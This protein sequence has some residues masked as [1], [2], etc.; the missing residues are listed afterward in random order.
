VRKSQLEAVARRF[1]AQAVPAVQN[2]ATALAGVAEQL[3]LPIAGIALPQLAPAPPAQRQALIAL[4]D[5]MARADG[6][7]SLFE[8]CLTRVVWSYLHDA[9]D[10]HRRSKAGRGRLVDAQ[11]AATTLL[12]ALAV[13]GASDPAAQRHAF[14]AAVARVLPGSPAPH[15]APADT[16]SAL[17]SGW[18]TLDS[19]DPR[20]KQR[21]VEA[22]VTAVLD[23]GTIAI[24]EGE[25]LRAA[26]SLIH[27]PIPA[28]IA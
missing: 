9:A 8:Y 24:A 20:E 15:Q 18:S 5:D 13:A 28:L 26:C 12:A 10:P 14:D 27:V 6:V 17:D 23:D 3:W 11:P 19:L 16:W 7:V 2:C 4:L 25:L 1:G 22:M 21:L